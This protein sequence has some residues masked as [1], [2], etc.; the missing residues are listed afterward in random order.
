MKG[1]FGKILG[2]LIPIVLTWLITDLLEN[3]Q[4]FSPHEFIS[5][6]VDMNL[7]ESSADELS[8]IS[9]FSES[10]A[11]VTVTKDGSILLADVNDYNSFIA[12]VNATT[13]LLR[14]GTTILDDSN[15][16]WYRVSLSNGNVGYIYSGCCSDS[17]L[18]DIKDIDLDEEQISKIVVQNEIGREYPIKN[19]LLK[20]ICH[21]VLVTLIIALIV[22]I[23]LVFM[24]IGKNKVFLSLLAFAVGILA[25]I[26]V[27]KPSYKYKTT[28]YNLYQ[29]VYT[30]NKLNIVYNDSQSPEFMEISIDPNKVQV[31]PM[32]GNKTYNSV[33]FIKKVTKNPLYYLSEFDPKEREI[34][35]LY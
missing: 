21:I 32:I 33:Y 24:F 34:Y 31:I 8:S 26:V 11:I 15:D 12:T 30:D 25:I 18:S 16:S 9:D 23:G 29:S 1:Y 6:L 27:I 4:Y 28:K 35:I 5:G 14:D 17:P 20:I 19:H 13:V 22:A 2:F 3:Q 7:E 10:S